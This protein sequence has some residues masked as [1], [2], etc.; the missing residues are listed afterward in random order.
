MIWNIQFQNNIIPSPHLI[1]LNLC[2]FIDSVLQNS[3]GKKLFQTPIL[4]NLSEGRGER[5]GLTMGSVKLV[6]SV[7]CGFRRL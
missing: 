2:L 1:L 5:S 7:A 3:V 4:Q 6:T